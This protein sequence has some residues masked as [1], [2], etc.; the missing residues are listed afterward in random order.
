MTTTRAASPT[1]VAVVE[2]EA[3]AE[4]ETPLPGWIGM[5][6][7]FAGVALPI[8]TLWCAFSGWWDAMVRAAGHLMVTVPL[9]FLYYPARP[10][11][12][13]A[14]RGDLAWTAVSLVAFGW[15]VVSQE[16]L[17]WRMVYVDPLSLPDLLL[18]IAAVVV[19]LEATRRIIGWA[20][21]V[22][23][24]VFLVYALAGPVMPGP[25]AHQ[26]VAIP[27][28]IDHLYLVPEGLFNVITGIMATYLFT[29][30]L[31]ASLLSAAGGDRL[32]M[33][34]ATSMGGRF[35]GGSAKVAVLASALMGT[36]S[37]S[38]TANAITTGSITIP[39]MIRSGFQR[40]HAAAIETAA[41]VGGA[42]MPPVMGAGVFIMAELTGI[43]LIT[44][45]TYSVLPAILY[46]GSIYAYVHFKAVKAGM[47]PTGGA[48][49]PAIRA[50]LVQGAH[51]AIP[52]MLLIWTLVQGFSPFY[53]SSLSVVVLIAVSYVRRATRLTPSRIAAAF[54][55]T[56]RGA[57]M[58]TVTSACAAIVM[59]VITSTGLMLKITSLTLALSQ[60]SLFICLLLV[61]VIAFV[62]G[63]GLP[64]TMSYI[65][66]STLAAPALAD[67]G[68][69]L[70]AAHL[71]IFWF[72]Q[73]ATITPPLCTTAFVCANIAGSP[74]MRTGW[75]SFR[76]AKALYIVPMLFVYSHLLSGNV[77]LMIFDAA[78]AMAAL[79]LLPA[80]MEGYL[81]GPLTTLARVLLGVAAVGFLYAALTS[82]P[83]TAAPWVAGAVLLTAVVVI[84][85]R[86]KDPLWAVSAQS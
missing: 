23:T 70:L 53:A 73:D 49:L 58:L 11:R 31:F 29:F 40:I 68:T 39:L 4:V 83:L 74:P 48:G 63:M 81:A 45:L 72:S 9:V 27:L 62:V 43:P 32:I 71:V 54:Q 80:I 16:R 35:V 69:S 84:G 61:A 34:L 12:P 30:L 5:A 14:T 52:L 50:T 76:V 21:V 26:G 59:G 85:Q 36:V 82:S 86:R 65:L 8:L 13:R 6:A 55:A 28:L 1:P 47:K 17:M 10:R 37:G 46:F 66:V 7:R 18:G 25:L 44:I 78:A 56:T 67:L 24:L 22:T 60:G 77:P 38:T 42:I 3:P 57:L 64:V 41:G 15:I 33:E 2:D 75:E 20:L 51:L 19:V 79:V